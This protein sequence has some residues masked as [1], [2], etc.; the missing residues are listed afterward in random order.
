[1]E[2]L[3]APPRTRRAA[4]FVAVPLALVMLLLVVVLITRKS[5]TDRADFNPLVNKAAP[6]IVG[7]TLD[8]KP[9]D[10]DHLR[11]EWVVVNFFATWCV[12]CQQEHGDLVSFDRRHSQAGDVQLISVVFNDDA[13]AVRDFYAKNGG[14]WPVVSG[15][16][17]RMALDYSVV[18]VPDTYIIDPLG[19]VRAR[20]ARP[21]QNADEID[22]RITELSNKLFGSS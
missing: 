16:Q 14:T 21:V 22:Q 7:T 20:I 19:I 11:G 6:A 13:N 18:K 12:P 4:I 15:N 3:A 10:L 9:F 17:G 5:A 2:T 1:M 8:G